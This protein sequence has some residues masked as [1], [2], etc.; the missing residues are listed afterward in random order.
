M[1]VGYTFATF[2]TQLA[3]M[4][5][6]DQ[7]DPNFLILL[8]AAIDTAELR[9][10]REMQLLSTVSSLQ[11]ISLMAG[12]RSLTVPIATYVVLQDVN[13]ITPVGTSNPDLGTRNP[14]LPTTREFLD[15]AYPSGNPAGVPSYFAPLNQNTTLFGQWPDQNYSLELIGTVRP[16]SLSAANTTTF[17][18]QFLPDLLLA[19]SMVYLSGYQ[20]NFGRASDDPAMA[21]SWEGYYQTCKAAAMTEENQKKFQVGGWSSQI[22]APTATPNRGA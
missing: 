9:I 7:N 10:Y 21:V 17:I 2:T 5:V 20:R 8:P 19:A 6:V 14:C 11:G 15:Y 18:S 3:T 1:T 16:A 12:L 4:A 22:A 13:V